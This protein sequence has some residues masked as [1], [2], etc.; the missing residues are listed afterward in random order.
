MLLGL[1]EKYANER[2]TLTH[3]SERASSHGLKYS[4]NIYTYSNPPFQDGGAPEHVRTGRDGVFPGQPD[5]HLVAAEVRYLVRFDLLLFNS[6][7]SKPTNVD[8]SF[9]V[10]QH[11]I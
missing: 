9:D 8:I 1:D 2:P 10:L 5:S 4:A 11:L 3:V 6:D 7:Y